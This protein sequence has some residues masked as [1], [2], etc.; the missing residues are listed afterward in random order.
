MPLLHPKK[1][2]AKLDDFF[3][4]GEDDWSAYRT[5]TGSLWH[6]Y[7]HNNTLLGVF[8]NRNMADEEAQFYREVTGNPAYVQ[9]EEVA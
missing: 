8:P 2:E 6:V 1:T 9:H 7:N 5:A 4:I 3:P